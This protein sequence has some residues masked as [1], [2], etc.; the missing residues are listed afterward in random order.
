MIL[1]TWDESGGFYDHVPPPQVDPYGLGFRVPAIVI[2]P[3][4]RR[5][6]IDHDVMDHTSTLRFIEA[7]WNLAALNARVAGSN[8]MSG[9]F[10]FPANGT[11]AASSCGSC[12]SAEAAVSSIAV[13]GSE[14]AP[15]PVMA[16]PV[17]RR[18]VLAHAEFMTISIPG[19][20][21]A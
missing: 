18:F 10:S 19:G 16:S 6:F 15:S 5:G 9:A 8:D 17:D 21:A 14:G 12:V 4:A 7:N 20:T 13:D 2:S 1:L 3:Y 11:M